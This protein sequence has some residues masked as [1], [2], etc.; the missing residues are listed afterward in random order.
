MAT[1][2]TLSRKV[3][4]SETTGSGAKDVYKPLVY[5]IYDALLGI[6]ERKHNR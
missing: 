2:R 6:Q 1:Y 4:D 3:R 5:M